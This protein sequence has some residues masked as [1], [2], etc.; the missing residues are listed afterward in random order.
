[1]PWHVSERDGKFC[2]IK[3][4]D[5]STAGCHE[6]REKANAQLRALYANEPKTAALEIDYADLEFDV[7][8]AASQ[9]LRIEVGQAPDRAVDAIVAALSQMSERLIAAEERQIEFVEIVQKLKEIVESDRESLVA[10]LGQ[11]TEAIRE[12]VSAQPE[13]VVNVPEIQMP[14]IPAPVVNVQPPEVTVQYTPQKTSKQIT[15][16]R[17]P[18]TGAISSAE[19]TDG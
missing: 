4:S 16:K 1:M 19:V 14:E 9:P 15:V 17:D 12:A 8:E 2:V 13:I 10:S 7:P 18:I 5:G 3:D 6:T 11:M